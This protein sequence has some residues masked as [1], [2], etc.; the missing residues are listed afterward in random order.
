MMRVTAQTGDLLAAAWSRENVLR[1]L[2]EHAARGQRVA[3][4]EQMREDFI[5]AW[6]REKPERLRVITQIEALTR[7][8]LDDL[9][10]AE[11]AQLATN[12]EAM[13]VAK[14]AAWE[15]GAREG[16]ALRRAKLE[17][18]LKQNPYDKELSGG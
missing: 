12:T 18:V 7:R 5:L 14:A 16:Y 11:S 3:E 4:L 2:D 1:L 10:A 13:R 8:L 6:A 15:C 9:N 17:S